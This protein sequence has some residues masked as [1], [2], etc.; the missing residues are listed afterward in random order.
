MIA[1]SAQV[2]RRV[3]CSQKMVTV[4]VVQLECGT[5]CTVSCAAGTRHNGNT[6][7]ALASTGPF[8]IPFLFFP[9]FFSPF[10]SHF[11]LST[12]C[13]CYFFPPFE[14]DRGCRVATFA[15]SKMKDGKQHSDRLA[16]SRSE[17]RYA[18]VKRRI[19]RGSNHSALVGVGSNRIRFT[20]RYER[21]WNLIVAQQRTPP[22]PPSAHLESI[23]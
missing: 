20:G 17:D 16:A 1:A 18:C 12:L 11:V 3:W 5:L 13:L 2:R 7:L 21:I 4:R 15:Q 14:F 23:S 19:L 10:S 9:H 22:P 8:L 6:D